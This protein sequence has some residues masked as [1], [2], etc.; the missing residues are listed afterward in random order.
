MSL[1]RID[2]PANQNKIFNLGAADFG[3]FS[4]NFFLFSFNFFFF[5]PSKVIVCEAELNLFTRLERGHAGVRASRAPEPIAK[6]AAAARRLGQVCDAA[7]GAELDCGGR[8][9]VRGHRTLGTA[10]G[11]VLARLLER[12]RTVRGRDGV[13]LA[14]ELGLGDKAGLVHEV[15]VVGA[16]AQG[17]ERRLEGEGER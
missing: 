7:V 1:A 9:L 11:A 3:V 8:V 13:R 2:S 15:I 10:A 4:F 16:T 12:G 14:Q 5:S 6:V 17:S